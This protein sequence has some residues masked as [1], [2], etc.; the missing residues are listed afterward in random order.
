MGFFFLGRL[1][2]IFGIGINVLTYIVGR[3]EEK[4]KQRIYILAIL[5]LN[6]CGYFKNQKNDSEISSDMETRIDS[7]LNSE[8]FDRKIF[9]EPISLNFKGKAI[10]RPGQKLDALDTTLSF[11]Y[12]PNGGFWDKF[13]LIEDHLSLDDNLS[14]ELKEGSINGIFFFSSDQQE[15][16]IFNIAGNWTIA[17]EVSDENED[18]IIEQITGKLFPCLKGKIVFEEN[19][20]YENKKRDFVEHFKLKSPKENGYSWTMDYEVKMK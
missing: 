17:T 12:D 19:W 2:S 8:N 6:S 1:L 16:Q 13:N 9:Y 14:I 18:Q 15:K 5:F 20:K 4:L 10:L 11:R 7:I 3:N